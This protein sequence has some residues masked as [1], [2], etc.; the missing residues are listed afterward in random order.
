M[1]K[2]LKKHVEFVVMQR[3]PK[4]LKECLQVLCA[5]HVMFQFAYISS[6]FNSFFFFILF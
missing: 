5:K 4:E 6:F 2:K 1:E 3:E